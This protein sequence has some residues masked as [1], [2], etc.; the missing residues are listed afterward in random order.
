M[1]PRIP[2]QLITDSLGSA[3]HTLGA[4]GLRY[5][6][7]R[8]SVTYPIV[9]DNPGESGL[10]LQRRIRCE[11]HGSARSDCPVRRAFAFYGGLSASCGC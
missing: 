5:P 6:G 7:S 2:W 9:R 8:I 11:A 4:T 10:L 3:D 1:Y